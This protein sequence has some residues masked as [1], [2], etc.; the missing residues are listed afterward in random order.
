MPI[1]KIVTIY[2]ESHLPKDGWLQSCIM[3]ETITS[4]T[5]LHMTIDK[6][7][8]LMY[9]IHT[10]LCPYC[11]KNLKNYKFQINYTKVCQ[12]MINNLDL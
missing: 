1:V 2:A 7:S 3:C 8:K 9:E 10:H 12:N 11:N 4:K 6:S 5:R